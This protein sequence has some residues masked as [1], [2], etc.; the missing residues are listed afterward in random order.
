MGYG[1]RAVLTGW[2]VAFN[3]AAIGGCG[4]LPLQISVLFADWLPFFTKAE[5]ILQIAWDLNG[6][7][8]M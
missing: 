7:P 6:Y 1:S 4:Y 3:G 2:N 8:I 5:Q